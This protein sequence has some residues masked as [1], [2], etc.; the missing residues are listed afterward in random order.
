MYWSPPSAEQMQ[1]M[2]WRRVEDYIEPI[3][4]VWDDNWDVLYLF[5]QYS[6]QLRIGASGP[7]GFDFNVYHHALD[8]KGI[9]ERRWH[10]ASH[11]LAWLHLSAERMRAN[12]AGERDER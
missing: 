4:H 9:G 2:P 8:R 7:I 5:A 11:H 3:T 12:A 10:G 6:T 1:K